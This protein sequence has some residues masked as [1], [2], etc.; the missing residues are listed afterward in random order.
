M[1]SITVTFVQVDGAEKTVTDVEL[2][3]SLM[4]V[5]R[6]N[7]VEGILGDCGGGCACASC[8]VYVDA[9]WQEKV[10]SPDDVE[11]GALDMVSDV[12]QSNSRLSCQIVARPELDGLKLT[13]APQTKP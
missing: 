10:G 2:G 1:G 13:V 7:G 9:Q 8:H 11:T 5:A 12:L 3:E 6:A 4:Q